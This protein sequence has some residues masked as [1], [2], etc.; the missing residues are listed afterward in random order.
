MI[1]RIE[2]NRYRC[3]ENIAVDIPGYAVL[4][5][6]NGAGKTTFLDVPR[7]TGC[8]GF[9]CRVGRFPG[10]TAIKEHI[11]RQIQT[12]E[13]ENDAFQVIVIDPEL[14]N[15]I[16]QLNDHVARGLGFDNMLALMEDSDFK[17][18][19]PKD[20]SK[21]N[22]PKEILETLLRKRRIPRSSAI[23]KKITS[24][25]SVKHCQDSSFHELSAA[26]RIWFPLEVA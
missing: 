11:T 26:L 12:T 8:Y 18:A 20:A 6:A 23:Y 2:A 5:G 7:V 17:R 15:W 13:W 24:Q 21:P 3:L 1:T 9:R 19:W 4:V 22:Q 10:A 16:W 25:V 14:E